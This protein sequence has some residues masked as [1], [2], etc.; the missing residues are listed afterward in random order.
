MIYIAP[1]AK[2]YLFQ[3]L[4]SLDDPI[5]YHTSICKR[6]GFD[7]FSGDFFVFRD[8]DNTH[9]GLLSYDGH[10]FQWCLKRFSSGKVAWWPD[11]KDVVQISPRDLQVLLWGGNPKE[12]ELPEMW[13]YVHKI[14]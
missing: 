11:E 5:E 12:I 13:R 10:G 1:Q 4:L 9:I 2:V 3:N 8:N 6:H 7:T 14:D